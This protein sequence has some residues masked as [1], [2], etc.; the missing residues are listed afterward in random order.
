MHGRLK[1]RAVIGQILHME[2]EGSNGRN[3]P[4][5]LQQRVLR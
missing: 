1:M 3:Q 2:M 5:P 4:I